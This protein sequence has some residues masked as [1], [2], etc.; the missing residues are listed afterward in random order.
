MLFK[1]EIRP[2]SRIQ[3]NDEKS[4]ARLKELEIESTGIRRRLG[5]SSP[6]AVI[7]QAA[8]NAVDDEIVIVEAD[9]FG[10]ATLT[11]VEGNYPIDFL[12]L[13]ETKFATESAATEAAERLISRAG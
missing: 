9:G 3:M 4:L 10:G 6:N 7:Y 12:C 2:Y 11:I 13:R 1:T 5:I 8:L